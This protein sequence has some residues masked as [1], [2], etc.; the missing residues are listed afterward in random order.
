MQKM[1]GTFNNSSIW[2]CDFIFDK[3]SNEWK[4]ALLNGRLIKSTDVLR[5]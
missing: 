4:G 1:D 3:N 5:R 2:D